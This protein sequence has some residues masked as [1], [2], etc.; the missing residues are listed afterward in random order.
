MVLAEIQ[1]LFTRYEEANANR[2]PF[3]NFEYYA[4]PLLVA[5]AAFVLRW[6]ADLDATCSIEHRY[7]CQN[8]SNAMGHIYVF[9]ITFIVILS[10]NRIKLFFD[11]IKQVVPVLVGMDRPHAKEA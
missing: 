11:Y 7:L 4:L 3:R 8:L 2:N 1:D 10:F 6:V 9:L 5:L